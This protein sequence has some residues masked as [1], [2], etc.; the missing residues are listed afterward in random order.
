VTNFAGTGIAGYSGDGTAAARAQVNNPFGLV[1]GPDNALWFA[2]YSANVVRR[3][4]TNGVIATA[5]GNGKA[6]Y[7]GDGGAAL[8]ASLTHPHEIRFDREGNL[9]IA[10][11]GNHVIRRLDAR[12]KVLTTFAGTGKPGNSGDEDLASKAEWSGQ[13]CNLVWSKKYCC[14]T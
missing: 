4:G 9:F 13:R 12:T 7:S 2:D 14:R 10:D 5:V 8:A 1:R 11:T 6:A 3:I